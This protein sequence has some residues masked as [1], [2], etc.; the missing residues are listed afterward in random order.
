MADKIL[1]TYQK[2][3]ADASAQDELRI[4]AEQTAQLIRRLRDEIEALSLSQDQF[5]A[6][7]ISLKR[8]LDYTA[9]PKN[10]AAIERILNSPNMRYLM[11]CITMVTI[12]W[13]EDDKINAIF[14]AIIKLIH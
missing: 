1:H 8:G 10:A 14:Q 9:L 3:K 5:V 12:F 13:L 6:L 4:N 2:A 11:T 7:K